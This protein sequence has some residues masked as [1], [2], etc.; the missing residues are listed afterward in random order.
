MNDFTFLSPTRLIVGRNAEEQTGEWIRRY[1]GTKVLVHH[2]SMY[3]KTSGLVD[4]IIENIRGA[5]LEVV[6]LGGVVPNPRL[7][8]VYE[9]IELC[10]KE[11]VDFLLAIGGGSVIDSAKAI[12]MGIRY[13]GDV[14]DFF[15]EDNGV[16]RAVETEP[17][18]PV[19]VVLTIAA[20]GSEGS[21]SCVITKEDENLKRFCDNDFHRPVF[22]IEN[23]VLTM[24]LPKFQTACGVIDIFSHS[25]ER[26]FSDEGVGH[27]LTDYLC[28]AIFHTCMDCGRRLMAYP[29]DYDARA[30]IMVASTISHNGLTGMG[31]RNNG[32]WGSHFIEHELSGEYDVTHGAGLAAIIPAWMK[33]VYKD[34]MPMFLKWATRVMGVSYDY[35]HP[36]LTVLEAIRRLEDFF[37][38]LGIP[39]TLHEMPDVGIVPEEV[40][41]KMARRVRVTNPD[42]T[43]G[44]LK[45]LNTEDIVC[46][47]RLAQ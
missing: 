25:M 38:S 30:N 36:E 13:A 34:N 28:E 26:Y 4:K 9:G 7:S 12:A 24:S 3:C 47:F 6:E 33:Y 40:M 18:V 15:V 5:G 11:G 35:E 17:C 19:G 32:D 16:V 2:D 8:L 27:D 14:W 43:V 21:N 37:R 22:A 42:G 31:R 39:T 20:T 23:P 29:D 45:P 44:T 41:Y 10:R 1:G 46:I